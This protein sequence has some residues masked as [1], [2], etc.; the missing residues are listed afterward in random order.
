[1]LIG[2]VGKPSAGKST[3]F[4][5]ATLADVLIA[6]Y[7]F[8]TIKPNHGTGFVRVERVDKEFG[9][10]ANPRFGFLAGGYRFVPTELMDVAGL[11]KDAHKGAGMGN[12]FLDDLRQADAF[13]HIVDVAGATND[14]GEPVEAGSH[15]PAEDILF[16]ETELDMWYLGILKKGWEKF[17]RALAVNKEKKEQALAR[18]FSGLGVKEDLMKE[19]LNGL[20]PPESVADWNDEWLLRI[21]VAL[22]RRTKPMIIACN[23]A[24]MASGKENYAKLKLQFPD[25]V[26]IPCSSECEIAL[27][28]AAKHGMISYVPGDSDFSIIASDKL[29]GRQK[30]ALSF[31]KEKVLGVYGSTGVQQVLDAAAFDLLK[32]IAIFPGGVNKLEDKDGNILPDCFLMPQGSTALDFAFRLH[33]DIGKG[34]IRAI[35]V[36]SKRTVGKE[37]V[38]KHRDVIEIV[39]AR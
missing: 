19:L 15:D 10:T 23:K 5:A 24:D 12:Q 27:K 22:R 21:A 37:H 38:L 2:F 13:I 28:E 34:F 32:L 16:L 18:Q 17:A 25:H 36:R 8:A 20:N 35:D 39:T 33:T 3:F 30:A 11:V 1:M 4:K 29:S 31:I 6:N 26:L 9:V 7:P 14:K